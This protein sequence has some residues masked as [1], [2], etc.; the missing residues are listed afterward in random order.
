MAYLNNIIKL[1]IFLKFNQNLELIRVAL[2]P[3]C[4]RYKYNGL[5]NK[6]LFPTGFYL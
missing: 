3:G 4:R 6:C 5:K 1:V 2:G